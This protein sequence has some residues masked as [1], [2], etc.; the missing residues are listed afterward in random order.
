MRYMFIAGMMPHTFKES[1][2]RNLFFPLNL[3]IRV[4]KQT[5]TWAKDPPPEKVRRGCAGKET[6]APSSL[7]SRSMHIINTLHALSTVR[8]LECKGKHAK[9]KLF[10][11]TRAI[12]INNMTLEN[13]FRKRN[14]NKKQLSRCFMGCWISVLENVFLLTFLPL[15]IQLG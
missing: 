13:V 12:I 5:P 9:K 7:R 1:R 14:E 4:G 3:G 15:V 11:C 10:P 8:C 6:V 2:Q